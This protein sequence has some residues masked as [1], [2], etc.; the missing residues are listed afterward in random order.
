MNKLL[1]PT[2]VLGLAGLA[3]FR[4]LCAD[5]PQ[6][7]A[8]PPAV[9]KA[10]CA[11]TKDNPTLDGKLDEPAWSK[12]ETLSSFAVFWQN[13]T[14][15]TATKP[16][17]VWNHQALWFAAEMEDADLYADVTERNGMTWTNDVI[18]LFFKPAE[19][20]LPYYEFQ[21][22]AANTPLTLFFPSRG[23]GGY[24]RFRALS[25]LALNAKVSLKGTLNDWKDKDTGWTV[26]GEIPWTSFAATGGRPKAGA[27][28]RFAL[29][30]Y[31]YAATLERPE[32]SSTAPLT[33]PDFHRYEDYGVL[34]FKGP[35]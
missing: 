8:E 22:N 4:S 34:I 1:V 10:N 35:E 30:R 20:A 31:D 26:E 15:K 2:L 7:A 28:W 19:D 18:E 14:P 33:Q 11:W 9:R 3:A 13:R 23:S 21:V 29:C 27:Q 12:A 25:N 5:A 32:L 17:L 6:A 24:Q 16:R